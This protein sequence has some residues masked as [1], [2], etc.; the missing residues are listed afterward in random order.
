MSRKSIA[1]ITAFV[2]VLTAA[3]ALSAAAP[4][5][6]TFVVSADDWNILL[7]VP[8]E[9]LALAHNHVESGDVDLAVQELN[10]AAAFLRAEHRRAK[11]ESAE[12]LDR[13]SHEL[14]Q[15]ATQ[16]STGQGARTLKPGDLDP[17]FARACRALASECREQA[18][19]SHR[20]KDH[21]AVVTLLRATAGY[22]SYAEYWASNEAD[23]G[24]IARAR[25]V[26]NK[27][28]MGGGVSTDEFSKIDDELRTEIENMRQADLA[29]S[30]DPLKHTPD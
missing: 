6:T 1:S 9:L 2:A 28:E 11:V 17:A 21:A 3:G 15:I 25:E 19:G 13:S 16:L 7:G 24:V 29:N 5:S 30:Q 27:I 12:D 26:A 18:A 10:Q 22:L 23:P 4:P 8:E 14:A 20:D